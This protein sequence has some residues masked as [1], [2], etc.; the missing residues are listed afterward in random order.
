MDNPSKSLL[1]KICM[2]GRRI[3]TPAI[4]WGKDNEE[5]AVQTLLVELRKMHKNVSIDKTGLRLHPEFNFIGASA[6]GLGNCDCHGKFLVE[7]KCPFKHREKSSIYDCFNDTSFCIGDDLHLKKGHP[8]MTQVQLQMNVHLIKQVFFTVWTPK[9]CFY[10]AVQYDETFDGFI[11]RLV[12]FH[13]QHVAR[14]LVTR[15]LELDLENRNSA[16]KDKK[17]LKGDE[18][19]ELFCL[20]QQPELPGDEMIGCDNPLCKY[21]WFHFNC[22]GLRRAPKGSWYCKDCK[23]N[24]KKS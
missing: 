18:E 9:F 16:F 7:I 23:K 2:P 19:K 17:D 3:N 10:T 14:E 20:C 21:K 12:M 15:K 6:D 5:K 22:I 4:S 24:M 8:Y 1:L 13:K 11:E